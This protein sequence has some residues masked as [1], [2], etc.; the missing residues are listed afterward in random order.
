MKK[1]TRARENRDYLYEYS[2]GLD[3]AYGRICDKPYII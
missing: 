2:I 3:N 1:K